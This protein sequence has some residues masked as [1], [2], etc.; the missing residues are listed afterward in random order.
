MKHL[1]EELKFIFAARETAFQRWA[2][3]DVDLPFSQILNDSDL[4]RCLFV[5]SQLCHIECNN[6]DK[7]DWQLV[8][9]W[10]GL[11]PDDSQNTAGNFG[12]YKQRRRT[13][14]NFEI[15]RPDF[16]Y[17]VPVF[18]GQFTGPLPLT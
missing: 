17:G 6:Q 16:L 2:A 1:K 18:D 15:P 11:R 13:F 8:L 3:G 14:G 10:L 4:K 12:L 9:A 5:P 7:A